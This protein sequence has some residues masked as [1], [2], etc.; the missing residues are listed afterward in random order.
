MRLGDQSRTSILPAKFKLA[1]D[2]HFVYQFF[3]DNDLWNFE[4]VYKK[5]KRSHQDCS[6]NTKFVSIKK[7]MLVKD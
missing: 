7:M 6:K 1:L 3:Y 2:A 5:I 4:F